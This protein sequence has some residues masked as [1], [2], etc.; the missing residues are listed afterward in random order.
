MTITEKLKYI[1][2]LISNEHYSEKE[3]VTV[4]KSLINK[5]SDEEE[6]IP[7][8]SLS[9][10]QEQVFNH[11]GITIYQMN[12][13]FRK[14]EVVQARQFAHYKAKR[15]TIESL[16]YIGFYFG[17]KDHATVLHSNKNIRGFLEVD[18]VF[19]EEHGEFLNN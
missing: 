6:R 18:K 5:E 15:F 4:I 9:Q 16:A 19:R 17:R 14:R 12:T 11:T 1:S 8:Y 13:E 3:K 10:I 7:K 2:E